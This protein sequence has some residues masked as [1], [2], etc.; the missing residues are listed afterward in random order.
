MKGSIEQSMN[1]LLVDDHQM[2]LDGI[3][4]LLRRNQGINNIYE[5]LNGEDALDIIEDQKIDMVLTDFNMPKTTG[6]ELTR[7]I[8]AKYPHIKIIVI[9]MS[10]SKCF[11]NE[12]INSGADGYIS[13]YVDNADMLKA[14]SKVADGEK[15]Y[16]KEVN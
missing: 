3:K 5:A 9:S 8:K 10:I 14:I 13:K 16:F 2:F 12:I 6:I 11:I 1:I 4:L 7:I 15:C